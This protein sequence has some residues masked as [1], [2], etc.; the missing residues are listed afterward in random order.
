MTV[1]QK[2]QN[3]NVYLNSVISL[4]FIRAILTRTLVYF[5]SFTSTKNDLTASTFTTKYK[6]VYFLPFIYA[7]FNPNVTPEAEPIISYSFSIFMLSLVV[8]YCFVNI[9]AYI[10]SI[11]LIDKYEIE[12]KFNKYPIFKRYIKFYS[13]INKILLVVETIIAFVALL[14][15][16]IL[17]FF[18]FTRM[19]L[20]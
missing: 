2:I 18:L 7:K 19:L 16:V 5:E 11:Y 9:M 8:L 14:C 6:N 3:L 20:L 15:I 4:N 17:N 12:Q 1:K 13:S 10:I